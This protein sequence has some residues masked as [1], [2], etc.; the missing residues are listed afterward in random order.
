MLKRC[1]N[2]EGSDLKT[3]GTLPRGQCVG[4]GYATDQNGNTKYPRLDIWLADLLFGITCENEIT[5]K[6]DR[7]KLYRLAHWF[8]RE[9]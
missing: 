2:P 3:G 1:R 7:T 9:R 4:L 6:T 5:A 8:C